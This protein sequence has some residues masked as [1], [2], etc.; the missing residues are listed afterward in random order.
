MNRLWRCWDMVF[1]RKMDSICA[2]HFH[3]PGHDHG[4][5]I[6]TVTMTKLSARKNDGDI[7]RPDIGD[8]RWEMHLCSAPHFHGHHHDHIDISESL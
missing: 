1:G 3:H 7:S 8:V 4:L 6:T 5:M 2:P